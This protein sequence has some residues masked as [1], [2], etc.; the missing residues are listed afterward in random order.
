MR[1]F[2]F[3]MEIRLITPSD[4]KEY[5]E[6]SRAFYASGAAKGEITD[7]LRESFWK[8][9]LK[10]ELLKGYFFEVNGEVAGFALTPVYASQEFGGRVLWIDELF[11]KPQ[12]RGQGLATE[13]FG[14]LENNS[15]GCKLLRLE[16]EPDNKKAISLYKS[17]GFENLIYGQMIKKL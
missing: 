12:F 3:G 9:I 16:V 4:K 8:E 11:V 7:D 14:F 17:L 1:G 5:F 13:F 6:M 2:I 15:Q 10:G